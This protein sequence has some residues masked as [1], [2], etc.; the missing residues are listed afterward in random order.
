[1][2]GT[3]P[4]FGGARPRAA[5]LILAAAAALTLLSARLTPA[6]RNRSSRPAVDERPDR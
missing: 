4:R 1:M 5:V 2:S 6:A 3:S